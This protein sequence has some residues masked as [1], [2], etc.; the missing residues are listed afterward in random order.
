MWW[1]HKDAEENADA[2]QRIPLEG[3]LDCYNDYGLNIVLN[4][5]SFFKLPDDVRQIVLDILEHEYE[6]GHKEESAVVQK[7]YQEH[8]IP[9]DAVVKVSY[10]N[11]I[12]NGRKLCD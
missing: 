7:F 10:I 2:Y 4:K 11:A 8:N 9:S 1:R 3:R 5:Y 6:D 12:Y